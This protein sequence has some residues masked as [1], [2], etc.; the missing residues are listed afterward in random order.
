MQG[1]AKK[2][3]IW[4]GWA[5][6]LF[7]IVYAFAKMDF[8][9]VWASIIM[10]DWRW[11]VPAFAL[12]M[13]ILFLR[14]VRWKIFIEPLKMI[15]VMSTFA[16]LSIGFMANMILP[17]RVGEVVRALV[18]SE[19]EGIP[20]GAA[21]GTV[22]IERV[23][24]GLSAVVLM[25]LV[26]IFA[27]PMDVSGNLSSVKMAGAAACAG[28][29]L[30][31]V[32]IYLF[33]KQV[34]PVIWLI[35]KSTGLLPGAWGPKTRDALESLRSGL[36]SVDHGH[37][38]ARV[39]AWSVPLWGLAGP[40]NWMVFKA[41]GLNLPMEAGFVVV[42]TQVFGLMIPSAPGFVGVYHAAT[43]AGMMLYGV[44]KEIA[45]SVAVLMHL[46]IFFSLTL[47]GFYYMWKLS[48]SLGEIKQREEKAEDEGINPVM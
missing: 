33:H 9:K 31:F 14:A 4:A 16:A 10:A 41:F 24:D 47:P 46:M 30:L 23:F 7:F 13:F 27:S 32:A 48:Y 34:K 44:D 6:S 20:K 42:V 35:E 40:F 8:G 1:K 25:V 19:K 26:F 38:L 21:F 11:I 37:R 5:I 28:F 15:G 17:A 43:M 45:L 36:D 18:L 3:T 12:Q 29:I 22:V 2:I 39:V